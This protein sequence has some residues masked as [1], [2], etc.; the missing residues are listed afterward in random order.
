MEMTGFGQET[1]AKGCLSGG[2]VST[3]LL[4]R[5]RL[6]SSCSA[7]VPTPATMWVSAPLFVNCK[8]ITGELKGR[9]VARPLVAK[10]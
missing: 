3:L 7:P 6:P 1:T 9:A 5:V 10:C 2:R 4:I 8:L